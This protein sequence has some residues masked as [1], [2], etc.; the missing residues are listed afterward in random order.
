M[1]YST[2]KNGN[3]KEK[4]QT[5]ERQTELH[6][7]QSNPIRTWIMKYLIQVE[8]FGGELIVKYW[9]SKGERG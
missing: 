6:C 9:R 1:N 8:K 4:S 7:L 5:C 2:T 3:Q